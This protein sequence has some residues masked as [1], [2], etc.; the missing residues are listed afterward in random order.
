ML[1]SRPC[2]VLS[3]AF[4]LV[5]CAFWPAWELGHAVLHAEDAQH[6]STG[7]HHGLVLA[8]ADHADHQHPVLQAPAKPDRA[9][10]FA[11]VAVPAGTMELRPGVVRVRTLVQPGAPARASPPLQFTPQ[12]RAPPLA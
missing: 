9:T 5:A 10:A 2:R 3:I 4:L 7:D 6:L 11:I 8:A 12:P 1:R